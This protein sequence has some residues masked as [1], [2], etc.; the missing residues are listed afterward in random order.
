MVDL[1]Q[2]RTFRPFGRPL[3][4]ETIPIKSDSCGTERSLLG[5]VA[6]A[7]NP[8]IMPISVCRVALRLVTFTSLVGMVPA[9]LWSQVS[10]QVWP[11]N[12]SHP[13][14]I[15]RYATS[16]GNTVTFTVVNNGTFDTQYSR[17]CTALGKVTSVSCTAVGL[18]AAGASKTVT[19]TFSVGTAG[20]GSV[21]LTVT[22]TSPTR[23]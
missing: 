13:D 12:G 11:N 23:L 17:T 2:A 6:S 3:Q 9:A 15:V 16:T 10:V 18:I 7:S 4:P 1:I 21:R 22:A 5:K 8:E 19:A 20:T 14:P